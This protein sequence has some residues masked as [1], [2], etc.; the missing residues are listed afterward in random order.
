MFNNQAINQ[1]YEIFNKTTTRS[2]DRL[3]IGAPTQ[4]RAVEIANKLLSSFQDDMSED[5]YHA[6]I[7]AAWRS[8]RTPTRWVLSGRGPKEM[9]R[10]LEEFVF[11]SLFAATGSRLNTARK[12]TFVFSGMGPQW[13]GMGRELAVKLPR[14]AEHVADIDELF[15]KHSG[16][17]VWE[18]LND[19]KDAQQLPTA[20]AQTGNFLLQV[21]L[22]NLTIDEGIKPDAIVGHSAGEIAAAYAA[23]VY[24]LD[25]AVRIAIIRGELQASLAG[26]GAMLAVGLSHKEALK[27]IADI[28]GISIA[29]INDTESVTISGDTK[30]IHKLDESLKEQQ[31][32]SKVLRVEV[33]YHSPIMD[34]ITEAITD[35]LSFLNPASCGKVA[36]YSTVSGERSD[37]TEWDGSYWAANIRQ[38][39][40]FADALKKVLDDGGNSFIELAPHPVLSQSMDALSSGYSN[41]SITHLL[42]RR[43]SEY[44]TFIS[45]ISKLAIDGIGRPERRPSASLIAPAP[46][47]QNLW[48]EDPDNEAVRRGD[49][50]ADDVPLLGRRISGT[51][52]NFEVEISTTDY[53]WL[54]GHTV[55][56]FGA[57]VP[58]TMW[59]E[60]FSLA[61]SE[62]ED[63]SVQ[64]TNLTIV[65]GLPVSTNPM[66]ISTK[67]DGGIIKCM[68]RQ[69]G[70]SGEWTLHAV[71]SI[72]SVAEA[73]SSDS[74]EINDSVIPPPNGTP[75]DTA[76]L[77]RTLRNKGMEYSDH[78]NNLTEVI[79]G[80]GDEAWA[81]INSKEPFKVGRHSPWV[82][83]AGLQLLLAAAKD[84]GESM[85]LPFRIG[86]ANLYRPIVDSG[87]YRAYAKV[88][89]RT[90]NELIGSV[91]FYDHDGELLAELKDIICVHNQSDDV[92]L[93]NFLN[94]N[95]Y[96]TRNLSPEEIAD[97]FV[98][99]DDQKQM[100]M[101]AAALTN[102]ETADDDSKPLEEYWI[103]DEETEKQNERPFDRQTLGLDEI[104]EGF[105]DN[106]L[107]VV[108]NQELNTDVLVATK[109]I[110]RLGELGSRTITLTVFAHREQEWMAGLRRAAANTYGF[111][112]RV[113]FYD[114]DTSS[115]M[116]EVAAALTNEHEIIFEG[117]EPLFRRFEK[118]T[119]EELRSSD[120]SHKSTGDNLPDTTLS[121]NFARGQLSKLVAFEEKLPKPG[122]GEICIRIDA[123][124]LL[125]KD[126]GKIL[127]TIG[128]AP[129]HTFA[130]SDLGF[131]VAGVVVS[132][133]P[134]APFSVGDR[135]FGAMRRPYR[136]YATLD[137][138][139]ASLLRKIPDNGVDNATI[140]A[141]VVPWVTAM[142]VFDNTQ[143][144]PG[145]SIFIQSGAGGLGSVLCLYAKQLGARVVTSVG[146]EAKV[147]EVKK[148]VP[149][150]EVI[151]ARG[152]DIP[153][154][155]VKNGYS[156]FNWIVATVNGG[157][158]TSLMEL[159][160]NRGYYVDLGKPS[161][162]DESLLATTFDGNKRYHVIDIDQLAAR[163]PGWINAQLDTITEKLSDPA[164]YV[165]V[166]VYPINEMSNAVTAMAQGETTGCIAITFSPEFQPPISNAIHPTMDPEGNYLITGG[167]GAVGLICAQWL[168]SRGARHIVLS[169]SSGKPNEESQAAIDLL[170]AWNINVS[171]V[172]SDAND[173]QSM[174]E[175]IRDTNSDRIISGIIHAAGLISD[176]PFEDIG[177]DRI[178]RSF[179]PKL[180]GAHY[181]VDALDAM[182]VM[183]NLDFLLFTS[184]ICSVV[185][186]SIQATY[187]AANSGLDGIAEHLRNRGVKA[188]AMQLGPIDDETGMASDEVVRR[189]Y[190]SVGMCSVSPRNLYGILD[191]AVGTSVPHFVTEEVDWTRNSRAELANSSSSMLRH[192]IAEALSGTNHAQLEN[193]LALEPSK[194]VEVLTTMLSGVVSDVLGL[195]EGF[196]AADSNFSALGID[197]L[198]IIEVQ[199]GINDILQQDLPLARMYTQNG[200]VGQLAAGIS[201]H[202]SE[203]HKDSEEEAA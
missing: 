57:I 100:E 148:V 126:I 127:G 185:G 144:K 189:H 102:D 168:A 121:F 199:T 130:G 131:G 68:S 159:L 139:T 152:G 108:P 12:I 167:Y 184:S 36:L 179:G 107:W 73:K 175:L 151:V 72:S 105:E 90:D 88:L 62:G 49:L 161:D 141:H 46:Q 173:S 153:G 42:S 198:S 163:E 123:T 119:A 16:H 145:D 66:V 53:P 71:A 10:S 137:A 67:I 103:S 24:T 35:Q 180:R 146:T 48:D 183:N 92:E 113:I 54:S 51:N 174:F 172:K 69:V 94:R 192:I 70:K 165:P 156:D 80:E 116:L 18:A 188:C 61:L 170:R 120:T 186:H 147:A 74:I 166:S 8:V 75:I 43:E 91:S 201:E 78:F 142:T 132:T 96:T 149:D 155:L 106:L 160:T 134:D 162:V 32:F 140:I 31:I 85:Y 22:F 56:G 177:T 112:I 2:I 128:S 30:E 38:P 191:L 197:S 195:E 111:S 86:R 136:Q 125:W 164:N 203:L 182:D 13:G 65:Q 26:R 1:N 129:I 23:G 11:E 110:Q 9:R 98:T 33:P 87:D 118:I 81:I 202:L 29:A 150:I 77:Y 82:L 117:N 52:L 154:T 64:M 124:G 115:E 143:T 178:D 47:P 14:F 158:R 101:N 181:L 59:T 138:E 17:S 176:G 190:A 15:V 196:L 50:A 19:Q 7:E 41:I 97:R 58:A 3:P 25:E 99:E 171:V 114:N 4:E 39:V 44:T 157:A 76:L 40:L 60:L 63:K 194:Q 122:L 21:A 27:L 109:L 6:E 89:V 20:L 95:S 34:E 84:F 5:D 83:D 93:A 169:G 200:T 79:V 55:Q 135:V 187:A 37:G 45:H 28:P 193:L 133:G 104:E